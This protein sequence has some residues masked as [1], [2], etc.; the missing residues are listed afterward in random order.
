MKSRIPRVLWMVAILVAVRE[1]DGFCKTPTDTVRDMLDAVMTVQ[2]DPGLQGPESRSTRAA[3][4]KNIITDNFDMDDMA[5]EALGAQ[6]QNLDERKR[7]E[8]KSVFQDL[9]LDSYT[10]LVLDFLKKERIA[11]KAED[12][13]PG[14]RALVKTVIER[15]SEEIPVDYSLLQKTGR[16]QVR[17]V[18]VD[19][20]SIVTNYRNSFT[21]VIRQESYDNLL[22]KMRLQQRAGKKF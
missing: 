5:R 15:A 10:R 6:W 20:V 17:D 12:G 8:F 3:Q 7:S 21:R 9:F 4:V 1:A 11:Y 13:G 14:G 22:K 2:T 16:W 18:V 19:D